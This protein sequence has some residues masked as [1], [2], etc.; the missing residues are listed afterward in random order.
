ML[1]LGKFRLTIIVDNNPHPERKELLTEH[2]LSIFFELG[3]NKYLL[4]TGASDT[5]AENAMKL[6]VQIEDIDYLLISHAHKDHTGGINKFLEIN[7]KAK[8]CLSSKNTE[9]SFF[10]SRKEAIKDISMPKISDEGKFR[11]VSVDKNLK[12]NDDIDIISVFPQVYP[13]P[14]GNRTLLYEKYSE[15]KKKLDKFQHELAFT[16]KVKDNFI[17][18]S[19]CTHNGILNTLEACFPDKT[20]KYRVLA[21]IGGTHLLDSNDT[22]RYESQ[23]EI[24]AIGKSLLELYPNL[25]LISG[26]CTGEN[27]SKQ[28][29]SVMGSRYQTFY[30]G[31]NFTI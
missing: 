9:Y 23:E 24:I 29:S 19:S 6:G 16:L 15:G 27:I 8:I 14:K 7:T 22:E 31:F 26:H 21:Y 18:L 13:F 17:V 10:S 5:F 3:G 25:K 4:D 20:D 12:L 28:F 30:T 1:P 11:L 2:G